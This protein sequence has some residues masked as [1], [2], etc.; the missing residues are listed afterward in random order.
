[1]LTSNTD[2][3]GEGISNAIMEYMA[4]GKPVV[5]TDCGGNS[6]LIVEGET[7]YLIANRDTAGLI[8]RIEKLLDDTLLTLRMGEAGRR[9]ISDAFSQERMTAAYAALYR[10]VLTGE[11]ATIE[12]EPAAAKLI[13]H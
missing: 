13:H 10:D 12:S 8:K 2:T 7:G 11:S 4:L 9:R 5:A 3:H 1:V 6:E